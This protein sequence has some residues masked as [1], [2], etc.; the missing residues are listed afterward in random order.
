MENVTVICPYVFEEEIGRVKQ[1][2][3]ELPFYV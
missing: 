1:G 2:Y 3:W